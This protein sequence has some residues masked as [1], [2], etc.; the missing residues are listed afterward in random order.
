MKPYKTVFFG[1]PAFTISALDRLV[2]DDRFDVEAVVTQKAKPVGR[3]KEVQDSPIAMYA[4]EN[5]LICQTPEKLR[6]R[7]FKNWFQSMQPDVC[8]ISAYGKI[9]PKSILEIPKHGFFNIHPSLLPKYR[10]TAPVQY[11]LLNGDTKT[12][13]TL[14]LINEKMDEGDIL[15]QIVH[16]IEPEDT[17]ASLL[18]KLSLIAAKHVPDIVD[19][20]MKGEIKPHPQDHRQAT[21]TEIIDKQMGEIDWQTESAEDIVNKIR[22]FTPW[23]GVFT[24]LDG[25][26]FKIAEAAVLNEASS[27]KIGVY[28]NDKGIQT[29]QGLLILKQVQLE[30]KKPVLFSDFLR[31]WNKSLEFGT[32]DEA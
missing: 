16:P 17:S 3:S 21:Y 13:T 22:A 23:P 31:G 20:Y 11:A 30:G 8:I 24:Y 25:K 9:I 19:Q 2:Q 6:D 14:M 26:R 27:D 15:W 10:G 7:E 18:E 5:D 4:K 12:G 32:K 1:T 29:K 28:I